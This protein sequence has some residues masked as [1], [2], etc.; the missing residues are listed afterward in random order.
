MFKSTTSKIGKRI[1]NRVVLHISRTKGT[2]T[3]LH[4]MLAVFWSLGNQLIYLD[5]LA[6]LSSKNT[7]VL[8]LGMHK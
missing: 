8:S 5:D 6:K 3:Q 1:N 4:W 2:V 7:T